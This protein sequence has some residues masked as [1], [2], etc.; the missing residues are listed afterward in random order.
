MKKL[1]F[2]LIAILIASCSQQKARNPISHSEGSFMKESAERN[3]KLV[4][5]EEKTINEIIKSTPEIKYIASKQGYWYYYINKNSTD[6]ICPKKGD[7][8][9]FDYE[10]KDLKGTVIYSQEEL[11]NQSYVV[12]KQSIM[13]GLQSGIKM[14]KKNEKVT[15]LFPSHI[16]YGYHGDNK[17]I[18]ANEPLICTV[19]LKDFKK[20]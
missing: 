4:A 12:D 1:T 11:Q 18:G 10:V 5:G 8:A 7:V 19:T 20:I 17:K 3:I 2:I 6:T 9:R 14:M 15:F 16:A 13:T